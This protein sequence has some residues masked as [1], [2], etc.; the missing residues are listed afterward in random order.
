M[1][2]TVKTMNRSEASSVALKVREDRL[3][4]LFALIVRLLA[5]F[6]V[7]IAAA[8]LPE[9]HL[10]KVASKGKNSD[11]GAR[12]VIRK[13]QRPQAWL[14]EEA[15]IDVCFVLLVRIAL[16]ASK[17]T[18][19]MRGYKEEMKQAGLEGTCSAV[20]LSIA[21]GRYRKALIAN[22]CSDGFKYVPTFGLPSEEGSKGGKKFPLTLN[23]GEGTIV[24]MRL[25]AST[26]AALLDY[27]ASGKRL[28][29]K[30]DEATTV[31]VNAYRVQEAK[32]LAD[33]ALQATKRDKLITN[34]ATSKA[35]P[36][37]TSTTNAS[38]TN[39]AGIIERPADVATQ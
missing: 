24:K 17:Q 31:A 35:T 1:K 37:V 12:Y 19:S 34:K 10:S 28:A 36:K 8:D 13:G 38:A 9:I 25:A 3:A 21:W 11:R 7:R 39:G 14:N 30:L 15:S 20:E 16:Q 18:E 22:V 5:T 6:G 27:V 33:L 32:T 26:L 2:H 4:M 29:I 23:A